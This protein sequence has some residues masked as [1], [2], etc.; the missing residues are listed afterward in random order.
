MTKDK[1]Q[2]NKSKDQ[3]DTTL[4]RAEKDTLE[5]PYQWHN[6]DAE[7]TNKYKQ[8]SGRPGIL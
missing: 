1:T 8:Y 3:A 5:K 2:D 6:D 4:N 7:V